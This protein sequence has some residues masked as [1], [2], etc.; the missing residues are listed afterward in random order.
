MLLKLVVPAPSSVLVSSN[1]VGF[2]DVDQQTPFAMIAPFPSDVIEPPETA[3]VKP[4]EVIV[5]VVTVG[6]TI[7]VVVN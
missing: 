5:V 7:A 1:T 3:D 6:I 4:G 2:A